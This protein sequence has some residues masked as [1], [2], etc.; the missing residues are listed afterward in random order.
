[1]SIQIFVELQLMF[2]VASKIVDVACITSQI[3]FVVKLFLGDFMFVF[4][5]LYITFIIGEINYQLLLQTQLH[6]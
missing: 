1:M 6:F 5:V 4:P 2:R 3:T